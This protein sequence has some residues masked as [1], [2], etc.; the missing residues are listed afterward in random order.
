VEITPSE[1]RL[2]PRTNDPYIWHF[3]PGREAFFSSVF[4]KNLS[5]HSISTY[6]LL[7]R[8][9]RNAF[10]AVP[11]IQSSTLDSIVPVRNT[12]R[13]RFI[14][15]LTISIVIS[16]RTRLQRHDRET[17]GGNA[18]LSHEVYELR[19]RVWKETARR[20]RKLPVTSQPTTA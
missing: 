17:P 15:V 5:D 19:R 9:V 16:S 2:N 20:R 18:R 8:E 1:V 11:N 13:R 6:R 4:A 12:A 10:E 14:S 7:Y 3:L